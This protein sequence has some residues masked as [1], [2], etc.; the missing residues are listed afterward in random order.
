MTFLLLETRVTKVSVQ[1]IIWT[2]KAIITKH[3]LAHHQEWTRSYL[4]VFVL[5]WAWHNVQ[6]NEWTALTGISPS[7]SQIFPKQFHWSTEKGIYFYMWT[8]VHPRN[9]Q[10]PLVQ[11]CLVR[12]LRFLQ[13]NKIIQVSF[14]EYH[15]KRNFVERVHAEGKRIGCMWTFQW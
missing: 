8:M 7:T 1:V 12:L 6:K 11:M 2:A 9:Q 4:L 15:S 13:L 5:L 3:Y 14:A 10:S